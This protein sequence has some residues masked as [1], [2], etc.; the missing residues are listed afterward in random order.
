[1]T[2]SGNGY[3]DYKPKVEFEHVA[4]DVYYRVNPETGEREDVMYSKDVQEEI[5][6]SE[7]DESDSEG[8]DSLDP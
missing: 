4:E 3:G 7:S 8:S 5:E 2:Q 6:E 1:M